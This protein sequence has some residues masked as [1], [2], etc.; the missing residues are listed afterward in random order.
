MAIYNMEDL[1]GKQYGLL[2]VIGKSEYKDKYGRTLWKCICECK[3]EKLATTGDL[4]GDKIKSCGCLKIKTMSEIGKTNRKYNTY[5]LSRKYGI[6][7]TSEG[8]KFYFDLED[9]NKIKDY[10]WSKHT[11]NEGYII[12]TIN[13]DDKINVILMHRLITDFKWDVVD[14]KNRKKND[15]RKE[16]LREANTS[17]NQMNSDIQSNNTSGIIGVTWY[18]K[19]NKWLARIN[20]ESNKRINLGYYVNFDDAIIARLKAEKEYYKEFAPQ[21]HL[22]KKYGI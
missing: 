17:K 4:K 7:Y 12:T 22:F 9:Y 1:T 2:K 15:N 10:C 20:S 8:N 5:D 3:N 19:Y 14:H 21:R 6:G 11:D 18:K 13:N 16:N